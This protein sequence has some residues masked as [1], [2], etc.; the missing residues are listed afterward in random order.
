MKQLTKNDVMDALREYGVVSEKHLKKELG[1]LELKL[2]KRMDR[3]LNKVKRELSL[4][5]GNIAT[6]SPTFRQFKELE[7]RVSVLEPM[8]A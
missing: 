6:S 8:V 2:D 5:I 4:A 7:S 3:K 1:Q